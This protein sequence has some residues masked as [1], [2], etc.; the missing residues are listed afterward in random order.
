MTGRYIRTGIARWFIVRSVDATRVRL[1]LEGLF[2]FFRADAADFDDDLT[3][4]AEEQNAAARLVLR[5]GEPIAEVEAKG[6]AESK[7]LMA[8]FEG[9][10]SLHR[11]EAL[12]P[13][14][15]PL[16]GHLA[17]WHLHSVFLIDLLHSRFRNRNIEI[18][19]L[20]TA[21]FKTERAA[22]GSKAEGEEENRPRIRSVRF[23]GRHLLDSRPACELL[24]AGQQLVQL[25]MTVRFRPDGAEDYL[26]P[27]TVKL[28]TDHVV[29]V[30]GFGV[31][32]PD[33][34]QQLHSVV[35]SG[36]RRALRSGLAD[37]PGLERLA[38]QVRERANAEQDPTFPTIFAPEAAEETEEDPADA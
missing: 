37:P 13:A 6:E 7:A 31:V 26:L 30:T 1:R 20:N 18:L 33:I 3:L 16:Q 4:T 14:I 19:D 17:A 28:A 9:T 8:A 38:R 2:R 24:S 5:A 11:R 21:G 34:A 27:L 12:A 10:S 22:R 29:V 15:D 25:G 36:V 35:T 23:E 32:P